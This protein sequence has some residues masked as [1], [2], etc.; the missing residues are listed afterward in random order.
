MSILDKDFLQNITNE[1]KKINSFTDYKK[2]LKSDVQKILNAEL[3]SHIVDYN[4]NEDLLVF[5]C[6]DII[7]LMMS[8]IF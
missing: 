1:V 5:Y 8:S 3:L 4:S 6:I 7:I 2:Y